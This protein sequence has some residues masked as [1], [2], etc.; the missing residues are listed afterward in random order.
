[1]TFESVKNWLRELRDLG[2]PDMVVVLVGNKSDLSHSREVDLEE[3][4]SL[5]VAENLCF[6]ETSAFE[7]LNVEEAF[8]EMITRIH[9]ITS[10]RVLEAKGNGTTVSNGLPAGK[11]IVHLDEVTATRRPICCSW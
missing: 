4:K 7:N 6:M 5:A 9:Q 1:M 8:L 10:Q 11:E 2:N 3:G